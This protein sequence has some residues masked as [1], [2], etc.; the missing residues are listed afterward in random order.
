MLCSGCSSDNPPD[1]AFC[2]QCGRKLELICPACKAGVSPGA[3]FCKKCGASLDP[4][5]ARSWLAGEQ[6]LRRSHQDEALAH[7]RGALD[8]LG[9]LPDA[10]ERLR[11]EMTLQLIIAK[12]LLM[13]GFEDVSE[14]EP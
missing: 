10:S 4:A 9:A 12:A 2:E 6:A 14:A 3:R 7:A 13:G 8:L 11:A 1:A 5:S